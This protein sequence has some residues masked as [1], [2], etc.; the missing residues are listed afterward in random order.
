MCQINPLL[1]KVWLIQK[2]PPSTLHTWV[3]AL[4]DALWEWI[5]VPKKPVDFS[6]GSIKGA[7][8]PED[9]VR[10]NHEFRFSSSDTL[11]CQTEVLLR[12]WLHLHFCCK[13]KYPE[14]VNHWEAGAWTW[15][16]A[17]QHCQ[18]LLLNSCSTVGLSRSW[19]WGTCQN[20]TTGLNSATETGAL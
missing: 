15:E 7:V 6:G 9:F 2:A 20:S 4:P 10:H 17:T 18:L 5:P 1:W 14:E 3:P 8:Y 11:Q 12:R 13:C 16:E 19:S